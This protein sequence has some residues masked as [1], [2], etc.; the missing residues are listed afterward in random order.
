MTA[1]P[2]V[3]GPALPVVEPRPCAA[4]VDVLALLIAVV[5]FVAFKNPLV[6]RRRI[7]IDVAAELSG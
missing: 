7:L 5:D 2:P 6:V 1:G 4:N 3:Q